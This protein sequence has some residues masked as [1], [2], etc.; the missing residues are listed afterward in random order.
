[1]N[2]QGGIDTFINNRGTGPGLTPDWQNAGHTHQGMGVDGA[3]A[4]IRF[5]RLYGTGRPDVCPAVSRL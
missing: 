3:K 5:G 2:V 4:D 1:M